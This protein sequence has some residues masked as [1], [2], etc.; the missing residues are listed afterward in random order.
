[1]YCISSDATEATL[2]I[3]STF[4]GGCVK[5]HLQTHSIPVHFC[6][7]P[8]QS[9]SFIGPLHGETKHL[10]VLY[11]I[12]IKC[13]LNIKNKSRFSG[14]QHTAKDCCRL[15]ADYLEALCL[16]GHRGTI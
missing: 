8:L 10:W 9:H 5:E 14:L 7:E 4:L 13:M 16:D 12:A 6:F 11:N 1:M 2:R 15:A 3:Q